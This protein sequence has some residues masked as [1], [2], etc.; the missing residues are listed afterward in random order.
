MLKL[1]KMPDKDQS[2]SKHQS[3]KLQYFGI[4]SLKYGLFVLFLFFNNNVY[5]QIINGGFE[6]I[7]NAPYVVSLH[8]IDGH[9]CTGVILSCDKIITSAHCLDGRAGSLF[10]IR[11][12]ST[13]QTTGFDGQERDFTYIDSD[14]PNDDVVF[15]P[16]Y[17]TADDLIG[18]L[19][20]ITLE[21]PLEFNSKVQPIEYVRP[22]NF[23]RDDLEVG[24]EIFYAGWGATNFSLPPTASDL[25]QS[26][27]SNIILNGFASLLLDD[28]ECGEDNDPSSFVNTINENNICVRDPVTMA[29]GKSGDSG[30]PGV[31]IR[32]FDFLN[33]LLI[34]I[35]AGG[36]CTEGGVSIFMDVFDYSDWIDQQVSTS[37]CCNE[38]P[39]ADIEIEE[40][41]TWNEND[42]EVGYLRVE[43]EVTLTIRNSTLEFNSPDGWIYL[44]EGATLILENSHLRTNMGCDNEDY[45]RGIVCQEHNT[46]SLTNS[47]IRNAKIG[48]ETKAKPGTAQ[49]TMDN[50]L[51]SECEVGVSFSQI[52][53]TSTNP[54]SKIHNNSQIIN[55]GTG[56]DLRG[57][58][59]LE[60]ENV[61]FYNNVE[62]ISAVDAFVDFGDGID[63]FG[64]DFLPPTS[65][66]ALYLGG[67]FPLAATYEI[68]SMDYDP[69]IFEGYSDAIVLAGA[70][71]TQGVSIMNCDIKA[72]RGVINYG[73]NKYTIQ[74]NE[75]E[76]DL[77]MASSYCSGYFSKFQCNISEHNDVGLHYLYDNSQSTFLENEFI[78]M[79]TDVEVI[80]GRIA[81]VGTQAESAAN[82][83]DFNSNDILVSNQTATSPLFR[84]FYFDGMGSMPCNKPNNQNEFRLN[85]ASALGDYCDGEIGIFGLIDPDDDGETG[86]SHWHW[87]THVSPPE[88][89]G[90]VQTALQN[91]NVVSQS[92][93]SASST[94]LDPLYEDSISGQSQE[95]EILSQWLNYGILRSLSTDSFSYVE[96]FLDS[97]QSWHWQK[98]NV[99]YAFMKNDLIKA[100]QLLQAIPLN[101]PDQVAFKETELINLKRMKLEQGLDS[102]PITES[103]LDVLYN[104]ATAYLP[105][106]GYAAS[107]YYHLT[108]NRVELSFNVGESQ[109]NQELLLASEEGINEAKPVQIFPNPVDD[110]LFIAPLSKAPTEIHV[111]DVLGSIVLQE[112][113]INE[114]NVSTLPAGFYFALIRYGTGETFIKKFIK[115]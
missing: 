32:N 79:G 14:R 48:I 93:L 111:I 27:T 64:D 75:F 29:Q 86:V 87:P 33:P 110:K 37:D 10:S 68:G 18:D 90:E 54:S 85:K 45:W 100:N 9:F 58:K 12:G 105:S 50:S 15:H 83:F 22:E 66:M 51:I 77:T 84:Y 20:I 107:L 41:T 47:S 7:E 62:G 94:H 102:V 91:L 56:L 11:A 3:F 104:H 61:S 21:N 23:N 5:N 71:H 30:G 82:C 28:D 36:S 76:N 57:V 39:L 19:A 98:I 43:E 74:N 106:S 40:N 65:R 16:D 4:N 25:L 31:F 52:Q 13:D 1:R 46:V 38:G 115:E 89:I 55:C 26:A 108:G 95:L 6:N 59:N 67:T 2:T 96:N 17:S 88:F 101:Y 103:E 53:F 42:I 72:D 78:S 24:T 35:M 69:Y 80:D 99:G 113:N 34:G 70:T 97:M 92:N 109:P 63:F 112:N 73:T 114:I 8:N 81:N 44:D 60:L 49:I